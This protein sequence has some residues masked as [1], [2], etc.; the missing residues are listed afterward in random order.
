M[1]VATVDYMWAES[2][3]TS[4]EFRKRGFGFGGLNLLYTISVRDLRL[5]RI[6]NTPASVSEKFSGKQQPVALI[7]LP[8]GNKGRTEIEDDEV[9]N[10]FP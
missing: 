1:E 2:G 8:K 4:L 5:V 7:T 3:L 10:A 9:C 6:T